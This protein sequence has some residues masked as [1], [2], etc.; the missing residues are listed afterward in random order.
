[1]AF[2]ISGVV[3]LRRLGRKVTGNALSTENL[4][5]YAEILQDPEEEWEGTV[6]I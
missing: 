5:A 2:S 3:F 6:L 4:L 1:M